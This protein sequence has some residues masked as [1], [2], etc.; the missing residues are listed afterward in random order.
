[1]AKAAKNAVKTKLSRFNLLKKKKSISEQQ[2]DNRDLRVLLL[3]LYMKNN[4]KMEHQVFI[5]SFRG[6]LNAQANPFHYVYSAI[7]P[8]VRKSIV[9]QNLASGEMMQA[10]ISSIRM[11]GGQMGWQIENTVIYANRS[12][13]LMQIGLDGEKTAKTDKYRQFLN[14]AQSFM[15]QFQ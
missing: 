5:Y 6:V 15:Y 3:Q 8:S 9:L 14:L 4:P 13:V 2:A 1:M 12:G 10:F 7:P 11:E